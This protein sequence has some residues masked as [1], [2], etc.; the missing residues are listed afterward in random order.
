MPNHGT[1]ARFPSFKGIN[2]ITTP[3][4]TPD[5][6]LKA[7]INFDMDKYGGLSK[8]PGYELVDSAEYK[9]LW[10]SDKNLG[11]YA[12]RNNSLVEVLPDY[13]Y[14]VLEENVNQESLSFTEVDYTIYI[15]SQGYNRAII[16]HQVYPL[17]ISKNNLSP[18]LTETTGTLQAGTYQVSITY[19][20]SQ[21]LESGTDVSS[22]IT[23]G[24]NSGISLSIPS[25]YEDNIEYARVYCS[26]CDGELLYRHG[27]AMLG[28]T[29]KISSVTNLSNPL[30]VFNMDKPPN[31]E[32]V[33]HYKDR[34]L[35]ANEDY[36]YYSEPYR[37]HLFD[38]EKNYIYISDKIV[39]ILPVEDGIWV[40][41]DKIYYLSGGAVENFSLNTKEYAKMVSGTAAMFSG[42]FL[43]LENTPI[44][45]KWLIT[46]DLGIF[47]L[48]NQ[49]L[50]IN[51][52]SQNVSF[53]ES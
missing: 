31:G 24:S 45:F 17:G 52:T 44:G 37:Y 21:G 53:K 19:V 42:S 34:L 12:L 32:K 50:V 40:L 22:V 35:I 38:L 15:V 48:F 28:E 51:L 11:C 26:T 6:Y 16:D 39:D 7:S 33:I 13:S 20:N 47:C 49:G 2:N 36:I 46:T 1:T 18:S 9:S 43:H 8:R 25:S 5:D 41:A 27:M 10:C 30:R 29:Y 14:V 3:E 23:V 4:G